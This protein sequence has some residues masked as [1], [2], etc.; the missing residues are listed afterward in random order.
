MNLSQA[1]ELVN[2]SASSIFSKDDVIKILSQ[3]K[4]EEVVETKHKEVPAILFMGFLSEFLHNENLEEEIEIDYD[5]AEFS[6]DYN[7]RVVLENVNVE[8]KVESILSRFKKA[9]D[10]AMDNE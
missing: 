10:Y 2:N 6:L 8:V 7:N 4:V 5:S 9:I 1:I 3:V